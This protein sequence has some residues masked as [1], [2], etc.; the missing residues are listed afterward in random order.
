MAKFRPINDRVLLRKM[1]AETVSKGG[2][3]IPLKAQQ[4]PPEAEVIAVGPG[5][6]VKRKFVATTVKPGDVAIYSRYAGTEVKIDGEDYLVVR[7][8]ELFGVVRR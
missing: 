7:E 6:F 3:I 2:I 8:D 5:K 1:P 4:A